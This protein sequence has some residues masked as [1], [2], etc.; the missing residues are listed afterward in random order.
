PGWSAVVRSQLTA[1]S[2]SQAQKILPAQPPERL[3]QENGVNP[4][5]GAGSELRS[6]HCTPAWV[7]EQDSISKKK[8]KKVKHK[9]WLLHRQSSPKGYWLPIFKV[10]S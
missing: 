8:K 3:K 1:T 10:I 7:P 2:A 5:G 6:R 9:E 4:G